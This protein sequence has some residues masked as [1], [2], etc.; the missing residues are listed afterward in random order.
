MQQCLD[1]V[2]GLRV[3]FRAPQLSFSDEVLCVNKGDGGSFGCLFCGS[4]YYYGQS[5]QTETT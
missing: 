5:H 1:P 3:S 4:G 2:T